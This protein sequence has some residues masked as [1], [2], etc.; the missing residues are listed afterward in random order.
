MPTRKPGDMQSAFGVDVVVPVHSATRPIRRAVSSILASENSSIRA[1]VVCH[2]IS[3]EVIQ[4]NLSGLDFSRIILTTLEDGIYSPAGPLNAGVQAS[5]A[6]YVAFLGSDDEYQPGILEAWLS[7][8]VAANNPQLIIGQLLSDGRGRI[9]APLP[10]RKRS[11]RLEASRDLLNNRTAPVGTLIRRDFL[12]QA[13]TP[14]F[15]PGLPVGED[16]ELG[17][18]LWNTAST[19]SYSKHAEGYVIHETGEDRV[20][21]HPLPLREVLFPVQRVLSRPWMEAL[22]VQKKRSIAVKLMRYQVID[23]LGHRQAHLSPEDLR[24]AASVAS[25]LL[26]LAPG[27]RGKL[28]VAENNTLRALMA[29]EP[30]YTVQS[31][32]LRAKVQTIL[33]Q[34][35]LR[36]FAAESFL[37]RAVRMHMLSRTLAPVPI[38]PATSDTTPARDCVVLFTSDFPFGS[39][40]E[41]LENEID[42]LAAQFSKVVIVP[43]SYRPGAQQ[44]RTLSKNVHLALPD[45]R[46]RSGNDLS[47]LIY[48]VGRHPFASARVSLKALRQAK[49]RKQALEN[50]RFELLT[51]I[52][53]RAITPAA[54][55]ELRAATTPVFYA[56]W[57]HTQA[58]VSLALKN[59]LRHHDSPVVSR[60]HG[61]DLYFEASASNYLPMRTFMAKQLSA[62]YPV[63]SHGTRYLQTRFPNEASKIEVRHL[64]VTAAKNPLNSTSDSQHLVSCSNFKPL[65]RLDLLIRSIA[66]AQQSMP[67]LQWTH[68]GAGSTAQQ[69]E[70]K[71]LASRLLRPGSFSF[72][73]A[74]PNPS[75]RAWYDTHEV[76]GFINVS[77]SEGV[78]VT[79]MEALAHGIPVIATNVGGTSEALAGDGMF[80]GLVAASA[81]PEEIGERIVSLCKA[82]SEIY[83]TWAESGLSHWSA[84]WSSETNY[85]SFAKML[86]SS[87]L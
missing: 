18:Y 31:S 27:V 82:P 68:I 44:T 86:H 23:T 56:Y 72:V 69:N 7:E 57:F 85:E 42:H 63:S 30:A 3:A 84:E 34:N 78:P 17:L 70:I 35:P 40:E 54:T 48:T 55:R 65:K 67:D 53:T 10:R 76:S 58:R 24:A 21:G 9:M 46:Y 64:G 75:L 4:T 83:R 20:T 32:S 5:S 16:I 80:P 60:A 74:L 51:S 22:S 13:G 25:S 66:E 81:T 41:F 15:T 36:L 61:G 79:I 47:D 87:K 49:T 52:L 37:A 38:G 50:I 8:A 6:K 39:G 62:I 19:I 14:V 1:V 59:L 73:G 2:N 26:A 28:S 29:D 45:S 12:T 77:S 43:L 11:E 33:P 71:A